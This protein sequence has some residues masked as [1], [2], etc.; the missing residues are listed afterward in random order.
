MRFTTSYEGLSSMHSSMPLGCMSAGPSCGSGNVLLTCNLVH[1]HTNTY[2]KGL[3]VHSSMPESCSAGPCGSGNGQLTC[4][5]G[6]TAILMMDLLLMDLYLCP[7][8][9]NTETKVVVGI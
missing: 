8:R 7:L 9:A 4:D 1:Q 2:N 5:W 3:S 6:A